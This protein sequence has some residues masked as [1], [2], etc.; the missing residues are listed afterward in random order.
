MHSC[1]ISLNA[2]IYDFL[3]N[4]NTNHPS[5][6]SIKH[7]HTYSLSIQAQ[8]SSVPLQIQIQT[9]IFYVDVIVGSLA[10]W[11]ER[12]DCDRPGLGSKPTRAILLCPLERH[13]WALSPAWWPLQAVINFS[14]ISLKLKKNKIKNFKRTAI[15]ILA[16]PEAG[17]GNC[18]PYV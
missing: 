7:R 14:H 3:I 10:E 11:L 1:L 16:S 4:S 8:T 13:L 9:S 18:L 6:N 2:S 5:L 12:R 15:A 17:R